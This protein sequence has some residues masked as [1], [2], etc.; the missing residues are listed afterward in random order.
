M[1][2]TIPEETSVEYAAQLMRDHDIG[3]VPI[4]EAMNVVGVI[5]DRDIAVRVTAECKEPKHTAVSEVMTRAVFH[6][7]DDEDIEDA[8]LMMH[9]SRIRRLLV[10]DRM[11]NLVGILSLDDVVTRAWKGKLAGHVLSNVARPA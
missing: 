11:R 9:D 8:C 5:T 10:F 6:C 1:V 4:G 2:L 7:F 3:I